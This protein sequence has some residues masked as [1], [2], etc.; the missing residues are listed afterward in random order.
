MSIKF[1]AEKKFNFKE[2]RFYLNNDPTVLHCHHYTT[3]LT[4]LAND[5]TKFNGPNIM[6]S[7]S[8]EIFYPILAEY[9][10]KYNVTSVEDRAS[11]SE[12][13]YSY[14]GLGLMKICVD[15]YSAELI[16]SHLDEA[17]LKNWS[18][19]DR[20]VNY[21]TQGFLSAAF[22]A[23][24]DSRIGTFEGEETQSI[25]CGAETSKF[26]IDKTGEKNAKRF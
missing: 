18:I 3:L 24:T 26:T 20:P 8:E 17:W 1:K 25:A 4:Q 13:Y 16:H 12:Q 9:F 6:R 10:K 7:T 22:S 2:K 23:I 5:A 14:I 19:S 15:D 21:I 11:I